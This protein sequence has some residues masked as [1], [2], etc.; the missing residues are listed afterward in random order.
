MTDS[1]TLPDP[2]SSPGRSWS[3]FLKDAWRLARPY[4]HSEERWRA[5]LMLFVIV[6]LN[7]GGV[8]MAVLF[9]QWYNVFYNAL[10]DKNVEVFWSQM[11]RF[12][13]LAVIAIILAVYLSLIH[14]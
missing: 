7:L 12:S 9:N 5:R 4:F 14:I 13:W 2:W 1:H 11:F 3:T 8:Y 10:Q 6:A